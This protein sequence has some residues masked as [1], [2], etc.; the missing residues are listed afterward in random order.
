MS[1]YQAMSTMLSDYIRAGVP[2]VVIRTAERHRVERALRDIVKAL[3]IHA[4]CYTDSKQIESLSPQD[5]A[6]AKD[7]DSDPLPFIRE[8]FRRS[9]HLTFLLGDTRRLEQDSLYTR[10]LLSTAY[11][12]RDTGNTLVIVAVENVWQRLARFGL[13]IDLELPTFEER[14]ALIGEF[15]ARFPDKVTWSDG[16]MTQ[17]A[18]LLRGLSEVQIINL[19][20]SSLVARGVLGD[21]AVT[22]IAGNKDRLFTAVSNVMPVSYPEHLE[23]AGLDGLKAWLDRKRNV[24]FARQELLD[25]HCLQSPRGV[26]LMGVP[27]CGKSFSAKMIASRWQLPLFRFDIGSVYNKYVGETERRMQEALDYIDNVAPCV[28]WIDEIEKALSSGSGE[29]DVGN[30]ILGQFLFWL[31]ESRAKVFLVATAND[32]QHLPPELFRKGRFSESFFIDLPDDGERRA[33]ISLYARL[34]LH[35]RFDEADM[36]RL[37]ERCRG[38]SYSDIE[39][40]IKDVA[41]RVVFGDLLEA[42]AAQVEACFAATIPI[43]AERIRAIREWGMKNAQS[44][45]SGGQHGE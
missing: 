11:L 42:T 40:A 12:A 38:F 5:E 35:R 26:L 45:S 16:G 30:R 43:S 14:H 20:R 4:F 23:V 24:F 29:S 6:A 21:D 31:Q 28:L 1:D 32:V 10:E 25:R 27:G 2:L 8:R 19:L 9:R 36:D 22:G 17:L 39:Q 34:A 41:E 44:A 13:F 15:A 18:T 3:N 37:V 33:A 7:V